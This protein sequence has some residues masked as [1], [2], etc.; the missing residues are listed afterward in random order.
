MWK[1]DVKGLPGRP[2]RRRGY[3]IKMD[4]KRRAMT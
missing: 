3:N 1:L 2:G 4:H